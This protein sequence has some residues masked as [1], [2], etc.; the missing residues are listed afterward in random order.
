[1]SCMLTR[2][3]DNLFGTAKFENGTVRTNPVTAGHYLYGQDDIGCQKEKAVRALQARADFELHKPADAPDF[4]LTYPEREA[5]K[6][7]GVDYLVSLF[8]RSVAW[9]RYAVG[10]HPDF[11]VFARGAMASGLLP[12]LVAN[13]SGLL[14]AFPPKGLPGLG[15]GL[16]W[17]DPTQRRGRR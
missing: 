7:D 5:L 17:R 14:L 10:H 9:G 15:G 13:D 1:M 11:H 8:A 16:I 3:V 4:P 2:H 6:V 12:A